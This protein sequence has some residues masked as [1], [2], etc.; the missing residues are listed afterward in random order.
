MTDANNY[1]L[2][3][4]ECLSWA[5]QTNNEEHRQAFLEMAKVWTQL[6]VHGPEVEAPSIAAAPVGV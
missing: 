1:Q 3:A 2:F 6:A 4:R 5:A